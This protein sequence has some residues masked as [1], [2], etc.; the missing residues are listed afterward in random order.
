[1][2][3]KND[4]KWRSQPWRTEEVAPILVFCLFDSLDVRLSKYNSC[5][6]FHQELKDSV[7][8]IG[9]IPFN[10]PLNGRSVEF[11]RL[12]KNESNYL[13]LHG[14]TDFSIDEAKIKAF[15]SLIKYIR[16]QN[17]SLKIYA[18]PVV[19]KILKGKISF[20]IIQNVRD[21]NEKI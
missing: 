1:M 14:E 17:R 15:L 8:K 2:A 9:L 11:E 12:L 5:D 16:T 20:T 13:L 6:S 19:E 3:R 21:I 10:V 18:T 7:G 4:R